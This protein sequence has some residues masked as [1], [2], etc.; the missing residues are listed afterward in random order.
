MFER[1]I[2]SVGWNFLGG[3]FFLMT[4]YIVWS[5]KKPLTMAN[6]RLVSTLI[7][8]FYNV[9]TLN[10]V[11]QPHFIQSKQGQMSLII[12]LGPNDSIFPSD[13]K[14][15]SSTQEGNMAAAIILLSIS[16]RLVYKFYS[17]FMN[18]K[19]RCLSLQGENSVIF[20]IITKSSLSIGFI[21]NKVWVKKGPTFKN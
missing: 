9:H 12:F 19:Q 1:V 7:S 16:F 2:N 3:S 4:K 10:L 13:R 18:N 6:L 14:N 8:K 11:F 21:I 17:A 5:L 20:V 15:T